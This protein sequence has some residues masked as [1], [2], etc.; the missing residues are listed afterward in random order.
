MG[1][2]GTGRW[3]GEGEGGNE[4]GGGG[5]GKVWRGFIYGSRRVDELQNRSRIK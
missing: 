1:R 4:G 3:E 2:E 5:R